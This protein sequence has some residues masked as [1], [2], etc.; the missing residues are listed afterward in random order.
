MGIRELA[1]M[2]PD[3]AV[4]MISSR[5]ND[6]N[7]IV[8]TEAQI[9]YP[10]VNTENPFDFLSIL[11]KPF[12]R[13]A[14]LNIYYYIKIHEL[15]VPSFEK[16]LRSEHPSV[17]HFCILMIALFQQ[18]ENSE[19]II[20]LVNDPNESIRMEAIRTCG[21]LNLFE[22]KPVL[23]AA[24]PDETLKNQLEIVKALRIIGDD[25]DL[26]F[27]E[28]IFQSQEKVLRLET[29]RTMYQLSETTRNYLAQLNQAMNFELNLYIAHIKDSRN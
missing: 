26:Q 21:E 17:V 10:Y 7:D 6:S 22:S 28:E 27:L 13:W 8:R 16:W 3:Q 2:H 11:E 14:Q 20:R 18:R 23:K 1:N 12:S 4:E 19:E 5:L 25:S 9:C 15:P 24:F 29:C